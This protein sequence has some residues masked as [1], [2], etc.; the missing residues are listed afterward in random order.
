MEIQL[1][2]FILG[3]VSVLVIAV[4]IVS[5]Y[6]MVK[7]MKLKA[8]VTNVNIWVSQE[9]EN[10]KK[11]IDYKIG[12]TYRDMDSRFDKFHEKINKEQS[13]SK[14]DLKREINEEREEWKNRVLEIMKRADSKESVNRPQ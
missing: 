12:N 2:S 10:L 5:V 11:E 7:V 14:S 8:D 4:S 1:T 9:F 13:S 3:I 6:A